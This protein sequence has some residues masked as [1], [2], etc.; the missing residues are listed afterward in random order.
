MEAQSLRYVNMFLLQYKMVSLVK[1]SSSWKILNIH[2][3]E[4]LANLFARM[5]R[6]MHSTIDPK[7][8]YT[9]TDL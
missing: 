6:K 1:L 5:S 7:V 4:T 8:A 2:S 3:F 9:S